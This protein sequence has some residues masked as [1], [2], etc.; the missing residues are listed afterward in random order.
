M[1]EYLYLSTWTARKE[2]PVSPE[3]LR[4]AALESGWINVC[5]H[6]NVLPDDG[7]DKDRFF[8][9]YWTDLSKLGKALAFG[10]QLQDPDSIG[11]MA[12]AKKPTPA[13]SNPREFTNCSAACM[14]WGC[15]EGHDL[16]V[17]SIDEDEAQAFAKLTRGTAP[18]CE[19]CEK[20]ILP[21]PGAKYYS[22]HTCYYVECASCLRSKPKAVRDL[23][24]QLDRDGDGY[25]DVDAMLIYQ[26]S[27]NTRFG[28]NSDHAHH[29][30]SPQCR[31]GASRAIAWTGPKGVLNMQQ[32]LWMVKSKYQYA[33]KLCK[34]IDRVD[35]FLKAQDEGVLRVRKSSEFYRLEIDVEESQILRGRNNRCFLCIKAC[36][37]M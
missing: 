33:D 18:A 10:G 37:L 31:A 11:P 24:L 16:V 2:Y 9:A 36:A 23:F 14:S 26:W 29:F 32:F 35:R 28:L 17:C 6:M 13:E 21:Y 12:S 25:I 1:H 4:E 19:V 8:E 34:A 5:Q 22:C 3:D 15:P 27:L 30:F 20:E 7:V